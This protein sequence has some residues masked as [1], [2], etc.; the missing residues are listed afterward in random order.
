MDCIDC[1]NRPTH[2]F[3]LPERGVDRILATGEAS[4]SLPYFRKKAVELLKAEHGSREQA[5]Q[6]IPEQLEAFYRHQ[7]PDLYAQKTEEIRKSAR[8]AASVY[9]R[10]V[11]PEMKVDWGTYINNIGHTDFPG[12]FRCHDGEHTAAGGEKAIQQDCSACHELLAMD[13]PAPK[14]L[15]D[16]GLMPASTAASQ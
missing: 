8:A 6:H 10:N 5:L 11:F 7:Y 4:A 12:C 2:A 15:S 1:H 3:E 16:L 9:A 13:E 14:I